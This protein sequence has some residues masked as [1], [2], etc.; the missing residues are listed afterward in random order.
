MRQLETELTRGMYHPDEVIITASNCTAG[1]SAAANPV[2]IRARSR[3]AVYSRA[4][5]LQS[6]R[7]GMK[8]FLHVLALCLFGFAASAATRPNILFI[9]AD[10][11]SWHSTGFMGD[12]VVKT[13]NLDRLATNGVVFTHAAVTTSICMVSRASML[14][15]RYLS[16]MGGARVTP[17]TWPDTWPARLHA[18]GYYGGHIGKV[19]VQGPDASGYDFWAGRYGAYHWIKDESGHRIHSLQKDTDEALRFL[20][21]RPKDKPFFLQ[22]AYTVPHAEDNDPQQYLPMP[23]EEKLYIDDIVPVP[24]TANNDYWMKLPPFF[25]DQPN[26]GRKRW[27]WRFDTPEKY[28][29]Y[30]KNYYRLIS[31]MDRSIGTIVNALQA[32]GS[33]ESTIVVFIGDNGYFLGEHGLADKWYA[34]EESVRVPL[35]VYDPRL[36]PKH[37]AKRCDDWVLNVDLAP[38]FCTWAGI[39]PS[40]S[41]QGRDFSPLLHGETPADWRTDFLYQFKWSSEIIPASEGVCSKDWK[42]VRWVVSNTEEL[43]DLKND[44]IE[45]HNVAGDPAHATDLAHSR[46]RLATLRKEVGGATIEQLKNMPYGDPQSGSKNKVSEE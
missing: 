41:M 36:A 18:A 6:F 16:Q 12:P 30:T 46:A 21:T 24:K 44:P 40:K 25:R 34:Y 32:D 39:E 17:Q 20:K 9:V 3:F 26:E 19:H 27:A 28:Q 42:Y 23:Q 37:R 13:P 1:I 7:C 35:V 10:D 4:A 11:L 5:V 2:L 14:T 29:V 38:T 31:G 43:F 45:G 33:A 8:K 15:G 22:V